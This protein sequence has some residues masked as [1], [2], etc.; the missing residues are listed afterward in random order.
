MKTKVKQVYEKGS[1]KLNEDEILV[2]ENLFGVFDGATSIVKYENE[3]GE[4]G[5]RIVSSLA[6]QAFD[7]NSINLLDSLKNSN[8]KIRTAQLNAGIDYNNREQI[9]NTDAAVIKIREDEVD[10]VNMG[11]T[12]IIAEYENEIKVIRQIIAPD[13]LS[14]DKTSDPIEAR[15]QVGLSKELAALTGD[16]N[17]EQYADSGTLH[18]ENLKT[19]ILMTD[20]LILPPYFI[21]EDFKGF[22]DLYHEVG[23]EGI[24]KEVRKYEVENN[25]EG[26]VHDDVAAIAVEF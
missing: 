19:I 9:W 11:H 12:M 21:K 23:L 18:T 6:K 13:K 7:E 10:Y 5:G 20:G 16:E 25:K 17:V 26:K 4:T 3:K 15:K 24:L 14:Q 22:I 8:I 1:N 2:K